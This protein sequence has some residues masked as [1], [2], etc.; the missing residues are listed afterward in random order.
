MNSEQHLILHG[1]AIKKYADAAAVAGIIG[2]D[3]DRVAAVLKENI[4]RGRVV[5]TN[6]KYSLSPTTRVSLTGDYSRF[7][8]DLRQNQ[9]FVRTYEEFERVN[10]ALKTLITDWQIMEVAGSSVANDHSDKAYDSRIIDRLGNL[11]ERADRILE[12][13][14][15]H[16]P[17]LQIYR[18][19]LTHALEHAEDG[20]IEWVSDAK[21]ESYHTLWFE[22]HE[23]LLCMLGRTRSE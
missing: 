12:K 2:M 11:H 4:A 21:I 23:D 18:D 5:E 19:K 3:P 16:L 10:T 14:A 13:F 7:C 20:A 22:L 17:R 6:G 15:G 8:S 1:L 9:D